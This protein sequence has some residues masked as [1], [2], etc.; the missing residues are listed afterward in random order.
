[1]SEKRKEKKENEKHMADM[2]GG[3]LNILGMNLDLGKVFELAEQSGEFAYD[4][5]KLGS[6]IER[7]GGKSVKVGGYIR[8]RPIMGQKTGQ[9]PVER[10]KREEST[11]HADKEFEGELEP[12]TDVFDEGDKVRVLAE[13]PFHH[14]QKDIT[15]EYEKKNGSGELIVRAMDYERRVEI[16][17]EFSAELTGEVKL[18]SF[19]SGIV[20]AELKK[21]IKET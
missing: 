7:G 14:D 8:T 13:I 10:K 20:N 15:L 21:E 12:L 5:E 2:F 17:E 9:Q 3:S 4:L 19:K 11:I 18:R 1:M 6:E 16:K